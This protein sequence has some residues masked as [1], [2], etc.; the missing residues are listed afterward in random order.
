M[1]DDADHELNIFTE[2]I[3]LSLQERAAFL[4]TACDGDENLRG[5][6][7]ALLEAYDRV[8]N[9]LEEPPG[10]GSIG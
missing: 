10:E 9:F 1:K 4:D 6:V 5:K 7:Q 2:A 8:G 3:R